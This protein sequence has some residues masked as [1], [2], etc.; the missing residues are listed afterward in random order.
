MDYEALAKQFGG[1][2]AAPSVDYEALARQFGGAVEAPASVSQIP[3]DSAGIPGPR[4]SGLMGSAAS[5]ADVTLGSI[6]PGAIQQLGY[7]I[8]RTM[9]PAQEAQAA[10]QRA[11][12]PFEQPFGRALGVTGTPEYETEAGRRLVNFIG[13]NV[14]KGAKWI[15][16]KTGLP[17]ADVE[18]MIGTLAAP[19]AV[20]TKPALKAGA[21]AVEAAA[22]PVVAG[23]KLLAEPLLEPRRQAASLKAYERGPQIEAAREAQRLGILV[24]PREIQPS[25]G[26]RAMTA[27]AGERMAPALAQANAPRVRAVALNEMNLPPTTQLNGPQAFQQARAQVAEPY[28]QVKQLPTMTADEGLIQRLN[29]LRV[30]PN[31]IGAK[32]YAPAV[33]RIVDSAIDRVSQGL[34]GEQLL[35]EVRVLRERSQKTYKNQNA[36]IEALD[37]ADTNLAVANALES[38]I[39]GNIFNPRLLS[40]FQAARAKMAQTYAYEGATNFNTGVVDVKKLARITS[41]DNALTGDI[42]ALGRIAGNFPDV[43]GGQVSPKELAKQRVTRSGVAGSLGFLTAGSL[44]ADGYLSGLAGLGTSALAE[45]ASAIAARRIAAPEYQAGLTLTDPRIPVPNK[46]TPAGPTIPTSRSLAPYTFADQEV[47]PPGAG[48]YQPNFMLVP[49]V[50]PQVEMPAANRMLPPPSG[51]S[52]LAAIRAEDVRRGRMSR[53]AGQEAEAQAAAAEAAAPRQPTRGEVILDLDPTTGR[54]R[55]AGQGLKGATPETFQ[56]FGADLASAADKVAS[57]QRFNLSATEK[58]AWEKTKVDLS[59]VAPGFKALNDKAIAEKMMDRQ[60]VDQ[61]VAKARE[62]AAAF[63]QLAA[64]AKDAQARRSAEANRERMLDLA[65]QLEERIRGPRP[66]STGQQ[67][68]K[69]RAFRRNMLSPENQNNLSQ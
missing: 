69:T 50:Y 5:L 68:P 37:I 56:D 18:N 10:V 67:G 7:P 48:P 51:E 42:A 28:E 54:L 6:A 39:E 43:F 36:T 59:E 24:D 62:K 25:V 20:A 58:I 9:M 27:L 53:M 4:R 15:S 12:Q 66:V 1:A 44:G 60:W 13:Q 65:E 2:A 23:A 46:L 11:A 57:G 35:K 47:L 34:N 19:A 22:E 26:T 33:D 14:Q 49:N 31:M 45:G 29:A 17:T 3:T 40:Q 63:E 8:L 32:E 38:M 61:T 41:R 16:E 64:R 21:R 52:T 30:D 55:S